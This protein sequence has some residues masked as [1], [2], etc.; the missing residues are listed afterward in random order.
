M[1]QSYS[2]AYE[3][4]LS[5]RVRGNVSK[6][7][8]YRFKTY[9]LEDNNHFINLSA[10][11]RFEKVCLFLPWL[12][13]KAIDDLLTEIESTGK[14]TV[15]SCPFT[16][17]DIWSHSF[18]LMLPILVVFYNDRI[19]LAFSRKMNLSSIRDY[20]SFYAYTSGLVRSIVNEYVVKITNTELFSSCNEVKHKDM[21]VKW[22]PIK[23]I[24]PVV[25]TL[26]WGSN[27]E[28]WTL[29]KAVKVYQK[30][31]YL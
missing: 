19:S 13:V 8:Y 5:I 25:I 14:L 20:S 26:M 23:M 3:D 24:E 16:R 9:L 31:V 18:L 10:S 17:Y 11:V 1:F 2:F 7:R 6:S 4:K 29:Q 30:R 27:D 15:I 22:L 21:T 12:S 28:S